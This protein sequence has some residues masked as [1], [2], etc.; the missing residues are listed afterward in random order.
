MKD[1]KDISDL[2]LSRQYKASRDQY[3]LAELYGRYR[4]MVLGVCLKYFK[5]EK[6]AEDACSSIYELLAKRL[7]VHDIDNFKPWLY[8]VVKNFCFEQLRL[9]TNKN[10]KEKEAYRVYSEQIFH[11]DD[12]ENAKEVTKLKKCIEKLSNIQKLCIKDFYYKKL[13]YQ[14]VA[15]KNE[16]SWNQVRTNIQN[17]RRKLKKC[18]QG[19]HE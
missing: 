15:E 6:D 13:N 1:I 14:K 18:M 10:L 17:G 7:E 2:E 16:L 5:H 19:H 3:L 8:V 12:I 11:P 9:R 4:E